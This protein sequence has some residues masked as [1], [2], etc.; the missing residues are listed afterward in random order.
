MVYITPLDSAEVKTLACHIDTYFPT[1]YLM[2]SAFIYHSLKHI[3]T[4]ID[5]QPCLP[6]EFYSFYGPNLITCPPA[7]MSLETGFYIKAHTYANRA[8]Q[9]LCCQDFLLVHCR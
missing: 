6:L 8:M 1:V 5:F 3:A 9:I 2:D 7:Q 4:Q